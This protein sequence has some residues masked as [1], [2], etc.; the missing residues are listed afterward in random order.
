M[1]A[2]PEQ[3]LFVLW[4]KARRKERLILNDIRKHLE[5]VAVRELRFN[6]SAAVG[7]R[8]FYGPSL[9]DVARK[10]RQC[11]RGAFL[12]V[13]VRDNHPVHVEESI[14][15]SIKPRNRLM[16]ELKDRYRKWAH[17]SHR[18]HG[19]VDAVEFGRDIRM[20]T[21]FDA[22]AWSSGVP[23]Q[24]W[25]LDFPSGWG[26]VRTSD[27]RERIEAQPI[28]LEHCPWNS[29]T[30]KMD[31]ETVLAREG[32]AFGLTERRLFL[33]NKY[34]NDCFYEGRFLSRTC[35]VKCTTKAVRSIRSEFMIARD[36]YAE[37]SSV[38]AERLGFFF[39]ASGRYA[40][41]MMDK[42]EGPTLTELLSRGLTEDEADRFADDLLRLARALKKADVVHRD[43]F[44]DNLLLGSD[45]HLK[46]IDWQL[47]ARR[48][49]FIE[50]PW[51]RKHW[52]FRY[53]V[54]GVNRELGL[55]VWNDCHALGKILA[56]F[57]Q[58]DR[59]RD[60]RRRLAELQ[61][62]TGVSAPPDLLT[63]ARLS[64]YAVSLRLQ[65]LFRGR[66]YRKYAQ[67]VRRYRTICGTWQDDME[68]RN[69]M[70][71]R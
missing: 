20:L 17:G 42:V 69:G 8:S 46:A 18:V 57:P 70:V 66:K 4:E 3:H 56:H 41:A 51:M 67:L 58:T 13:V 43:L 45:G 1:S 40:F 59:V 36:V 62:T 31:W 10:I 21:G 29:W 2:L 53:V 34:I 55:G 33:S 15:G 25:H 63:L 12:L 48:H 54:F 35:V 14:L 30:G 5:V 68:M 64:F 37:D 16:V 60:V 52:K 9:P 61:P 49:P 22:E 38:V 23:K 47:A 26:V 65:M 6:G 27:P 11:G 50:D 28:Y 7:Y 39:A 32:R 19:T 71:K 24:P 44:S